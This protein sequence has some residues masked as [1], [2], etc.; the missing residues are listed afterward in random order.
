MIQA[1]ITAAASGQ[2]EGMP[3]IIGDILKLDFNGLKNKIFALFDNSTGKWKSK[4][5]ILKDKT[6]KERLSYFIQEVNEGNS[7]SVVQ[8]AQM[9]GSRA[10]QIA[11]TNSLSTED[12]SVWNRVIWEKFLSSW[13]CIDSNPALNYDYCGFPGVKMFEEP[14]KTTGGT[15]ST[16]TGTTGSGTTGTGE[17]TKKQFYA[18]VFSSLGIAAALITGGIMMFLKERKRRAL[19]Y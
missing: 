15:G 16:G 1:L 11:D 5:A 13:G 14:A 6:A 7:W 10:D 3:G 8:Y 18:N 2:T 17:V 12:K 9:Y 19:G 4:H